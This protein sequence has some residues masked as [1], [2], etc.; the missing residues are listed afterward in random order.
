MLRLPKNKCIKYL[1]CIHVFRKLHVVR[2]L[3]FTVSKIDHDN[4]ICKKL[5]TKDMKKV[6]HLQHL[7]PET[8]Q[9]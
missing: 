3:P 8:Q 5:V 2:K 1:Q 7:Y 4:I 6:F 9:M